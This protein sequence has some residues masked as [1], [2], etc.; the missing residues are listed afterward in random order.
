MK[1]TTVIAEFILVVICILGCA[2]GA[3]HIFQV[4][5]SAS[6][7]QWIVDG[8]TAPPLSL[9]TSE[10]Y[11]FLVAPAAATAPP[12]FFLAS[13]D[14]D[15]T[16][17]SKLTEAN[18][19]SNNLCAPCNVSFLTTLVDPADT[20]YYCAETHQGAGNIVSIVGAPTA[21]YGCGW[22]ETTCSRC[23][24]IIMESTCMA[25]KGCAFCI[26]KDAGGCVA[27]GETTCAA[28]ASSSEDTTTP[29][30]A[31]IILG[32]G[33]AVV[34]AIVLAAVIVLTRKH[35][36]MKENESMFRIEDQMSVLG[37]RTT[38]DFTL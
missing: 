13:D 15:N 17:D 31:W 27:E 20:I 37:G 34:C 16:T 9:A 26:D 22:R 11:V 21:T 23:Q 18:G 30:W 10:T 2:H 12:R 29:F 36:A 1:P 3:A 25:T 35:K 33:G 19:V 24:A 5:W 8:D 28:F 6:T 32:V 7:A 38:D 4:E 14:D